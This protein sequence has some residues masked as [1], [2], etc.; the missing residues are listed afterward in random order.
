MLKVVGTCRNNPEKNIQKMSCGGLTVLT[1]GGESGYRK[2]FLD[3]ISLLSHT[4]YHHHYAMQHELKS[5][6]VF[7]TVTDNQYHSKKYKQFAFL[8]SMNTS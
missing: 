6:L 8:F 4:H 3:F 1:R 7:R 2:Q 5:D